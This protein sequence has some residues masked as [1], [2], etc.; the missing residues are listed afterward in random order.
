MKFF[1][2]KEDTMVKAIR[3]VRAKFIDPNTNEVHIDFV[4]E[5]GDKLQLRLTPDQARTLCQ[6]LGHAY[7]AINPPMNRGQHY[8]Q[9]QG[10]E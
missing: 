4:N 8:S 1:K 3:A 7:E 10:M 6:E 5:A 2:G 9:W